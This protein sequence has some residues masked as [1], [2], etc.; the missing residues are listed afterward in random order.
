MEKVHEIRSDLGLP[1]WSNDKDSTY[2]MNSIP[3][4]GKFHMPQSN[5]A[6]ATKPKHQN[7][8][9]DSRACEPQLLKPGHVLRAWQ[10]KPLQ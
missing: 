8:Q 3:D 4:Q 10:E 7:Y 5:Y 9:A 2:H 6:G 1:W